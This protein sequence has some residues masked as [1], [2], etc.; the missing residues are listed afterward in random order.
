[1]GHLP[2]DLA[3][4]LRNVEDFTYSTCVV[5]NPNPVGARGKKG[6]QFAIKIELRIPREKANIVKTSVKKTEPS[7]INVTNYVLYFIL[8]F[9]RFKSLFYYCLLKIIKK[10]G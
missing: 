1:M 3:R 2:R 8:G 6:L 7:I 9:L 10:Y 4:A 5:V